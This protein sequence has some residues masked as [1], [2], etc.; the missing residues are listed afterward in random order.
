MD[1]ASTAPDECRASCADESVGR[2]KLREDVEGEEGGE[3]DAWIGGGELG[4]MGSAVGNG[5]VGS[6]LDPG[7]LWSER[8]VREEVKTK[9]WLGL[10]AALVEV[11]VV[12]V[13]MRGD[14][15]SSLS[16][17]GGGDFLARTG[18]FAGGVSCETRV[19]AAVVVEVRLLD[20]FAGG[21]N[22]TSNSERGSW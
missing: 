21:S 11:F 22:I 18:L 5:L 4:W 3:S 2:F 8:S 14:Q 12:V 13:E 6:S 19:D 15:P 17:G 16:F 1:R 10:R 9:A 7:Q 20:A